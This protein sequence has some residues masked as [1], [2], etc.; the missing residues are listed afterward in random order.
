VVVVDPDRQ[1]PVTRL[2]SISYGGGVQSTALVTLAADGR[3]DE[4]M[5]GPVRLAVFANTGDDSEHPDSIRYVREVATP[6][7]AER[8]IEVVEVRRRYAD[9]R[10]YPTLRE[11]HLD[12]DRRGLS[13][14][15]HIEG[16]RKD[17]MARRTCT[18]SWKVE[19][20]AAELRRRGATPD[21]PAITAIGI[22]TDE[23]ERAGRGNDLPH[24][25]RVYPLL[26]FGFNR[27]DC[28]EL[29]REAGLPVP[30]KSSCYFCPFHSAQTW[31]ELRRDRPDLFEQAAELED[32]TN[33][34][35]ATNGATTRVWLTR[36]RKPLREAVAEAQDT[37]WGGGG[38]GE[39]GC[40][41]GYCWT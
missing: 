37:L 18:Q 3:L 10:P 17:F 14:P 15:W 33:A 5:G 39:A 16:D 40:D 32:A 26:A 2:R 38:I 4:I 31:S 9:G 22:S 24:Q 12:P 25:R 41:E 19:P 34:R 36:R 6:W 13:L 11:I 7:A 20:V 23:I 8:G 28:A 27:A 35:Q 21:T 29:I 30:P 1:G